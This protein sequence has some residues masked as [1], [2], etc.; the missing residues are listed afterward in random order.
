M[1]DEIINKYKE[2]IDPALDSTD[3]SCGPMSAGSSDSEEAYSGN[4]H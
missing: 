1:D 3:G 4:Y 2:Y